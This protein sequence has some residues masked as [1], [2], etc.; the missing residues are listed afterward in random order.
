MRIKKFYKIG[1]H[2]VKIVFKDIKNLGEA[3]VAKNIIYLSTKLKKDQKE[4]VLIH[5]ILHFL[6][7]TIGHATHDSLSEQIY[8]VLKDNKMLK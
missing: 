4:S 2:K 6:N 7:T 1:G 3:D 8:Q 5:E